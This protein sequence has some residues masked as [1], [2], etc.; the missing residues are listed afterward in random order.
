MTVKIRLGSKRPV[1]SGL[2][3]TDDAMLD[4]ILKDVCPKCDGA[5][6]VMGHQPEEDPGDLF[7]RYFVRWEV[8]NA[9]QTADCEIRVFRRLVLCPRCHG[10]GKRVLS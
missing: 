9:R 5:G 4:R 1:Q 10:S 2:F 3:E 6:H 7:S 8:G